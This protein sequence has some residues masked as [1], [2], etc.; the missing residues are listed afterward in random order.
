M[1]G[2]AFC[3]NHA[4]CEKFASE[5]EQHGLRCRIVTGKEAKG[6]AGQAVID[7]AVDALIG[8]KIDLIVTVE[9]LAT[10][11]NRE[12]INAI[13]SARITSAAK[14]IQYIGRGSRSFID[15]LRRIKTHCLVFETN[16]T[17]KK[18][19]KRGRKPMRL[20]DAL[21]FNG[22]DP[23]AI[24]SMADG[25]QLDVKRTFTIEKDGTVN[26]A[27]RLAIGVVP[28]VKAQLQSIIGHQTLEQLIDQAGLQP[29]PN[30]RVFSAS[31]PIDVYW[32]DE[33][34]RL[35][36][37]K[38]NE[39]GVIP[40]DEGDGK[41]DAVGLTAYAK[42]TKL[43]Q[44]Q[45]LAQIVEEAGLTPIPGIKARSGNQT[46]DLYW[47]DDIDRLLPKRLN[48]DGI[49]T[50]GEGTDRREAIVIAKYSERPG[51]KITRQRLGKLIKEANLQPVPNAKVWSGKK[52][53]DVYWK[54]EVDALLKQDGRL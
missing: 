18:N 14:T 25:S 43:V 8:G 19:A 6:R 31:H 15:A 42:A 22:E 3:T 48:D 40:L 11:F 7:A 23:D 41:R 45:V 1:R 49:V 54:D 35:L 46:I 9:K 51:S 13:I 20:A 16:W 38:L 44:H 17:L 2:M 5:A 50:L 39:E 33:V 29:V 34:D 32:K 30:V 12:E 37:K 47:K 26:I 21:A 52:P 53:V 24:C 36:P 10:G 4:E 28:Y 27:G